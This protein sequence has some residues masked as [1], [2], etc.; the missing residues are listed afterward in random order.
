MKTVLLKIYG[1]LLLPIILF[2]APIYVMVFLVGLSTIVDTCFGIWKAKQ[3]GENVTSKACRNGLVPKIRSYVLIVLIL[4]TADYYIV[5]EFT[6]LFISIEFVST[7]LI[8]LGL[9]IIEVKS[10]DESFKKVKGY[11]FIAK[12]FDH[13]RN[14]K[15]VKDE[16]KP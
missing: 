8:S 1:S 9:I 12:L 3:L 15:K 14:I 6:M 7:K 10:M 4:F 16:F 2:F 11:S 5:N 13:I